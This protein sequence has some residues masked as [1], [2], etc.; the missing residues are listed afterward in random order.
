[1]SKQFTVHDNASLSALTIHLRERLAEGAT[2][3][4]SVSEGLSRSSQQNAMLHAWITQISRERGEHT[5][6]EVKAFCKL[7]FGVAIMRG[8]SP[9]FN[10]FYKEALIGLQYEQKLQAMEYIPL[11]SMMNVS[12]MTEF[13]TA[14]QKHYAGLETDPVILEGSE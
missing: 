9:E 2:M 13:L 7:H 1:M 6:A 3:R 14:I 5:P 10:E 8:A 11:T 12:Q 4:C